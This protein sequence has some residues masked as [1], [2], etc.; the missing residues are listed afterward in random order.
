[1]SINFGKSKRSSK[2]E[3]TMH[4]QIVAIEHRFQGCKKVHQTCWKVGSCFISRNRNI[5]FYT[6]VSRRL[7]IKIF[8]RLGKIGSWFG[9]WACVSAPLGKLVGSL[10]S[11][12][13]NELEGLEV[14]LHCRETS[15]FI[16]VWW[17]LNF[18]LCCFR[19]FPRFS[20]WIKSG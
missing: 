13:F 7:R 15:T 18:R 20:L 11:L 5:W 8:G 10:S 3:T 6:I 2:I 16:G 12:A 17:L 19:L 4:D 14:R 1:M 9:S